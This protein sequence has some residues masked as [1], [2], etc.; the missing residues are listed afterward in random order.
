MRWTKTRCLAKHLLLLPDSPAS[1]SPTQE[2]QVGRCRPRDFLE[3]ERSGWALRQEIGAAVREQGRERRQQGGAEGTQGAGGPGTRTGVAG[4][5]EGCCVPE[6]WGP[7][8]GGW[9]RA[10]RSGGEETP[11]RELVPKTPEVVPIPCSA[12]G[13]GREGG[14]RVRRKRPHFWWSQK[15]GGGAQD[16]VLLYLR[17][18]PRPHGDLGVVG[19][20]WGPEGAQGAEVAGHFIC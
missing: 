8:A 7:H 5:S 15:T 1:V 19:T 16:P 9:G 12:L 2:A 3:E 17:P 13:A 10:L 20:D 11:R 6:S 18:R 4:A 14:R